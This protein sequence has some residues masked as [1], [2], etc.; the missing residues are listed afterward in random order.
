MVTTPG[1][2]DVSLPRSA[3]LM[4][5][6]GLAAGV[7]A[8]SLWHEP[9]CPEQQQASSSAPHVL[10]QRPKPAGVRTAGSA[11]A[12]DAPAALGTEQYQAGQEQE[13]S[14]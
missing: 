8:P 5:P 10:P 11:S 13:R 14:G 9:C 12:S 7:G 2:D 4:S 6:A 3:F 1:G